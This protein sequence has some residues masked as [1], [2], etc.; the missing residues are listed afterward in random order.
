MKRQSSS[1]AQNINIP[2]V[3]MKES[4]DDNASASNQTEMLVDEP[5][6]I[7]KSEVYRSAQTIT[8]SI[9]DSTK[10]DKDTTMIGGPSN[11]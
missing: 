3:T 1:V 5:E 8:A 6:R 7:S 9:G 4:N 11:W 10:R 2:D